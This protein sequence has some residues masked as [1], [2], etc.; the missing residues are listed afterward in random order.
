MRVEICASRRPCGT[1]GR[2]N[3]LPTDP[4]LLQYYA[5]P[6]PPASHTRD[7]HTNHVVWIGCDGGCSKKFLHMVTCVNVPFEL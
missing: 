7:A 1:P 2:R 4:S 6:P 5:P 3:P